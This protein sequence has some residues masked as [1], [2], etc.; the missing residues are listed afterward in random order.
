M[1]RTRPRPRLP[2]LSRRWSRRGPRCADAPRGTISRG[3]SRWP[4]HS[5][6]RRLRT[7]QRPP[8]RCPGRPDDPPGGAAAQSRRV[9][10]GRASPG[11][12]AGA[13]AHASKRESR[14]SGARPNRSKPN[15]PRRPSWPPN[16]P[17]TKR[18]SG[19]R[20]SEGL[21]PR[22]RNGL[23]GNGGARNASRRTGWRSS[24]AKPSA[25]R[26]SGSRPSEG[27]TCHLT[28]PRPNGW[29]WSC[30]RLRS[31]SSSA[32]RRGPSRTR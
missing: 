7:R 3:T 27:G 11:A 23:S 24:D 29:N 14:Q 16:V 2:R 31:T 5:C 21:R 17:G 9:A 22:R 4:G 12:P 10:P 19:L 1:R 20:P 30:C 6:H 25:V 32:L 13:R 8:R 15:A 28:Q 26:R 18:P